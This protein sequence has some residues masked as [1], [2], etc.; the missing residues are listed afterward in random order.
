MRLP[1][2]MAAWR[3]EV[4]AMAVWCMEQ[5]LFGPDRRCVTLPGEVLIEIRVTAA[6]GYT[7]AAEATALAGAVGANKSRGTAPPPGIAQALFSWIVV[8][9]PP[10]EDA[11]ILNRASGVQWPSS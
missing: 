8:F 4:N 11:G 1:I 2:P 3:N 6:D 9:R 5:A 10:G 7:A